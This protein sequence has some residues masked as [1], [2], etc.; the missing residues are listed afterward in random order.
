MVQ[1]QG[2]RDSTIASLRPSESIRISLRGSNASMPD[3]GHEL[4]H[5]PQVMQ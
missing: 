2:Q 1:I 4:A 5:K 3:A